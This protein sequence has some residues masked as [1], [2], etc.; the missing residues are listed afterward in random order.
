MND[1]SRFAPAA[2]AV[3][4]IEIGRLVDI[5]GSTSRI[6]LQPAL[7]EAIA[8]DPD[9]SIAMAGQVGSQ[10]K[11][12]AGDHPNAGGLVV[13]MDKEHADKLA[14]R[15][16][17]ITGERPDV[18]HSDASDAS[19]RIARSTAISI[20]VPSAEITTVTRPAT[21]CTVRSAI[22]VRSVSVSL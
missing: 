22:V 3:D 18:V 17:R 5:G 6:T 15:L 9:P 11:I 10:I 8:H 12:R 16:A 13:A 7:L 21:A 1:F 19:A 14:G 20:P 4:G 2:A